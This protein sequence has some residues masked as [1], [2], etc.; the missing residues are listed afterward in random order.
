[1]QKNVHLTQIIIFLTNDLGSSP[2]F[3]NIRYGTILNK[4][5]SSEL[6]K[7]YSNL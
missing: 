4:Y 1:M 7:M 6:N 5:S 2:L 3:H